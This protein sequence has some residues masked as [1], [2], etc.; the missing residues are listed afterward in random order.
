MESSRQPE[1]Y[2]LP[3]FPNPRVPNSPLPVLLYRA[4]SVSVNEL[5]QHIESNRWLYGGSFGS[6]PRHH[7]HS[8]THECY[9]VTNGKGQMVLGRGP[10]AL[11]KED[12][13]PADGA[14]GAGATEV[15]T[16]NLYEGVK[17]DMN[18]G[19]AIV[20]P[21]G[22]AHSNVGIDGDGEYSYLGMYPE[23]GSL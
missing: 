21:A 8:V 19:D 3:L 10:Q 16:S 2:F 11:Q 9:V 18:V 1:Q 4:G 12:A 15:S 23:V 17:V 6:Y 14:D 5:R 22:V 13:G 7:F 20:L